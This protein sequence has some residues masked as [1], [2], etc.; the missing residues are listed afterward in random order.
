MPNGNGVMYPSTSNTY[1]NTTRL[2]SILNMYNY[3][4]NM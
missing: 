1:H 2:K 3:D 4:V